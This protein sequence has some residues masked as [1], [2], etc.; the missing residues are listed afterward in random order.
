M[1]QVGVWDGDEVKLNESLVEMYDR[2]GEL[3]FPRSQCPSRKCNCSARYVSN[4][5]QARR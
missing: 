1:L 4:Q 2:Q 3:I 5:R